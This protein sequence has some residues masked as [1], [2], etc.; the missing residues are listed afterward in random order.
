[1]PVPE[2][3]SPEVAV[4]ARLMGVSMTTLM[5][6][7]ARTGDMVIVC[8]AG[9]VGLLAAH[10]FVIGGYDVWIVE[11]DELRR[12]QAKQSGIVNVLAE[13]PIE[14]PEFVGKVA[15][16]MDCSG[17]EEAVLKACQ[18]VRKR[19]EVVLVGVPW[20]PY[21]KIK[22]HEI[23]KAIFFN[24]VELRSGWE[25]EVPIVSRN[26]VWEELLEGYNNA[27]YCIFGGFERALK[28]L[29][30]GRIKT[31]GLVAKLS[32]EDPAK[33]YADIQE[34]RISEPFI[35]YDWSRLSDLP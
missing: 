22:A 5:T 23:L 34:R 29:K 15:L 28:W 7:K 8:G 3:M 31:D 9:P 25:W 33:I 26:F 32:P 16:V 10:N 11:P 30:E 18:L 13:M 2:N 27:P 21:T 19:G 14:D 6:T 4:L 24:F 17:H 20:R 1:M 12:T 35:V